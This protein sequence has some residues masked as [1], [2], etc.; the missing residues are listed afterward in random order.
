MR[1][2]MCLVLIGMLGYL[3]LEAK[4]FKGSYYTDVMKTYGE[5]TSQGHD[6]IEYSG[7][8]CIVR[9]H[10]NQ[11]GHITDAD[12]KIRPEFKTFFEYYK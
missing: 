4:E 5:P 10:K 2:L 12:I 6:Y 8:D 9:F 11:D 1:K 3:C 7:K